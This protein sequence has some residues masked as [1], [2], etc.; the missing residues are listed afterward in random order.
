MANARGDLW[1]IGDGEVYSHRRL[2]TELGEE[3]FNTGS[4]H[5]AALRAFECDGLEGLERL[6]GAFAFVIAGEDGR[7]AA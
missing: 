2:R 5:E 1:L 4:D 3:S 7:F 6:W